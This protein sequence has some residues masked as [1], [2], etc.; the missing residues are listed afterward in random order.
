MGSSDIAGCTPYGHL[1]PGKGG[2]PLEKSTGEFPLLSIKTTY[3]WLLVGFTIF[4]SPVHFQAW[5]TPDRTEP[6]IH[7]ESLI[8]LLRAGFSQV[9]NLPGSRKVVLGALKLC[10]ASWLIP[11]I[12]KKESHEEFCIS[13][14]CSPAWLVAR[15]P[16]LWKQWLFLRGAEGCHLMLGSLIILFGC[17]T[18]PECVSKDTNHSLCLKLS[19]FLRVSSTKS[20]WLSWFVQ[21]QTPQNCKCKTREHLRK[22]EE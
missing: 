4:Q 7:L 2:M 8:W 17:S 19:H 13:Q 3:L 22:P 10:N 12:P 9:F 5:L 16:K 21:H 14:E 11:A 6:I 18:I 15:V 1:N 20:L